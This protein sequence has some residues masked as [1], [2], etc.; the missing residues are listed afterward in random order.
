[1]CR[2]CGR[3]FFSIRWFLPFEYFVLLK[4]FAKMFVFDSCILN[5]LVFNFNFAVYFCALASICE[6]ILHVQRLF[7]NVF[8]ISRISV[9]EVDKKWNKVDS[10]FVRESVKLMTHNFVFS[11]QNVSYKGKRLWFC[12]RPNSFSFYILEAWKF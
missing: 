7:G 6:Y 1:M 11:T 10:Y 9:I 2:F 4:N 5:V 12:I 8:A 3:N